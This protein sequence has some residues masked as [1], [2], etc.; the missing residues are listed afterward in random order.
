MELIVTLSGVLS[1]RWDKP[2]SHIA[3]AVEGRM[4]ELDLAAQRNLQV[5]ALTSSTSSSRTTLSPSFL[6][7]TLT[8]ICLLI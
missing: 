1:V 4:R 5:P 7:L 8:M 3:D 6:L 2:E